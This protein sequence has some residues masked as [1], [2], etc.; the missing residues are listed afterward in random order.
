M[1][2][3]PQQKTYSFSYS[4]GVHQVLL[5][6]EDNATNGVLLWPVSLTDHL[7]TDAQSV[8]HIYVY[9]CSLAVLLYTDDV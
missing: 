6:T 9:S 8:K 5:Y 1:T 3:K 2:G 7:Y 4:L